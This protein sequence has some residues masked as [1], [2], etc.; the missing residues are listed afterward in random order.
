MLDWRLSVCS[1]S[2]EGGPLLAGRNLVAAML[3]ARGCVLCTGVHDGVLIP[4]R[5]PL[6]PRGPNPG[7]AVSRPV[8]GCEP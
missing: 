6:E 7:F 8:G 5:G 1:S 3:A 2:S 4:T